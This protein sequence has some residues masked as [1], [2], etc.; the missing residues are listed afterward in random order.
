MAMWFLMRFEILYFDWLVIWLGSLVL[1]GSFGGYMVGS[2]Y[3]H[4]RNR[5]D[6]S[7]SALAEALLKIDLN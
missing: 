7:L 3:I 4:T 5:Q 1:E 2:T 6:T